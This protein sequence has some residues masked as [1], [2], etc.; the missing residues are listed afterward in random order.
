MLFVVNLL[1]YGLGPPA[2]G[3]VSDLAFSPALEEAGYA[4]VLDRSMCD[5]AER[6]VI[7]AEREARIASGEARSFWTV[8][9]EDTSNRVSP[10]SVEARNTVLANLERPVT[11]EQFVFCEEHNQSSTRISM[12]FLTVLYAVAGVFFLFSAMRLKRD[13]PE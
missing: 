13:M 1:G 6:A 12:L 5:A 9:S 11:E 4:E 2:A 8:L 3:I 10:I 7:F